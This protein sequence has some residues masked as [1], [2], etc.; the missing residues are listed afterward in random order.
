MHQHFWNRR[1]DC[2]GAAEGGRDD[3]RGV[4]P[5]GVFS[6]RRWETRIYPLVRNPILEVD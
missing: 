4:G 5:C 1:L 3:I 2:P 6:G